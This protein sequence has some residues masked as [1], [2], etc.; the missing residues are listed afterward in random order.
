MDG[1]IKCHRILTSC[2]P[3]FDYFKDFIF[4]HPFHF[5]QRNIPFPLK[6]RKKIMVYMPIEECV[7]NLKKFFLFSI[8]TYVFGTQINS[9]NEMALLSTQNTGDDSFSAPKKTHV[10]IEE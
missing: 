4:T 5:R 6:Y 3:C 2:F 1:G 7:T 10:K 9:L 8:K